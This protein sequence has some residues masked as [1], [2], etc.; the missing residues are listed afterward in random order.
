MSIGP[1][2]SDSDTATETLT[3]TKGW[4]Y[5]ITNHTDY[6]IVVVH[7]NWWFRKKSSLRW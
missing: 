6:D 4:K 5:T 1:S 7:E 3:T 2:E